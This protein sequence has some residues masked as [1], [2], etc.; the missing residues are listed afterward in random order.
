MGE[1]MIIVVPVKQVPE[2]SNV[3]LDPITGVM[4]R[5]SSKAIINPLDLYAIE[6]ALQIKEKQNAKVI[7]ITMGPTSSIKVLNEAIAIGCDEGIQ[8]SDRAFAGSDTWST[9]YVLSQAIKKIGNVDLV[10]T[11][12][13]ATDGDTGQVGPEIASW[14]N[15]PVSTYTSHLLEITDSSVTVKRLLE[16]GYQ[17]LRLPFPCVITVLKEIAYVRLATLKGKKRAMSSSIPLWGEKDLILDSSYLGLKGSPT[18][19]VKIEQAKVG[20]TPRIIEAMDGNSVVKAVLSLI[21]YL[22][23]NDLLSKRGQL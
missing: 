8:I 14:L 17:T 7:A 9:S 18:R 23:S 19:V 15:L 11:G 3:E 20:R 5:S 12:E 16:E 13:R 2:T 21:E 1:N 10:I 4:V 22:E 6:T